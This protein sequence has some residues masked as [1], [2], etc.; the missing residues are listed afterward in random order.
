MSASREPQATEVI[1]VAQD[2]LQELKRA[3]EYF[4]DLRSGPDWAGE[5]IR[6]RERYTSSNIG[7][8]IRQV[9][10]QV[11]GVAG[12]EGVGKSTLIN[13]I[14]GT[15]VVPTDANQPGT[16]VPIHVCVAATEA[17][18]FETVSQ[19]GRQ[20]CESLA[21]LKA[22]ALQRHNSANQGRITK[23]MVTLPRPHLS[24]GLCLVDLPGLEGMSV[25]F[26][27]HAKAALEAMD[28]VILVVQDR[29]AGPALRLARDILDSGAAIDAVV[30]NLQ[31]SKFV[32][33]SSLRTRSDATAGDHILSTR[34]YVADQF[35][36]ELPNLR[37]NCPFFA[38]HVPSM[39]AL[40]IALGSELSLP[41]HADEIL[42]FADWFDTAYS[43]GGTNH[44]HHRLLQ[45][46]ETWLAE[47]KAR[48][49][50]ECDQLTALSNSDPAAIQQLDDLIDTHK[51]DLRN[52]WIKEIDNG[53]IKLAME[54]AW[55]EFQPNVAELKSRLQELHRT[56][57][58]AV[59]QDWWS[60]NR[61]LA[62][63]ISDDIDRAVTASQKRLES[64]ATACIQKFADTITQLAQ[65]LAADELKLVPLDRGPILLPSAETVAIWPAARPDPQRK[66]ISEYD[67]SKVIERL[68]DELAVL[69]MSV[70][71]SQGSALFQA[72]Q[73]ALKSHLERTWKLLEGRLDELR[74]SSRNSGSP[75]FE[76]A[77]SRL[78]KQNQALATTEAAADSFRMA[79]DAI[80]PLVS[81]HQQRLERART[82]L[83]EDF[84]AR[85]QPPDAK[86]GQSNLVVS[87]NQSASS[88]HAERS[89]WGKCKR[90]VARWFGL[91]P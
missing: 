34:D 41:S 81:A 48:L 10:Q 31:L 19:D 84:E 30:I 67:S 75:L 85:A 64:Q 42:R 74:E 28:S 35:F 44:R 7:R 27:R 68:L 60:Q 13:A 53:R 58:A 86:T 9:E 73:S 54:Q 47:H 46:V 39:H 77:Q 21:E 17:M 33:T 3:F 82:Q 72:F 18:L 89:I 49:T 63:Q 4:V 50:V 26:R 8:L 78:Q 40:S 29:N 57:T 69:E 56:T 11:V 61:G 62:D 38:F 24:T 88:A 71:T 15:E 76:E 80:E 59:P 43:L 23:A 79:I 2:A 12:L 83:G 22:H 66:S 5:V 14:F 32:D 25:E 1:A 55:S 51:A 37:S 87:Q 36:K 6:K 52:R 20:S 16:A 90:A 70:N 91:R 45:E 65:E